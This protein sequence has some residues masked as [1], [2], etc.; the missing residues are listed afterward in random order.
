MARLE[1]SEKF[2]LENIKIKHAINV[3]EEQ[4]I[5]LLLFINIKMIVK[6]FY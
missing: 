1:K 3:K 6:K 5:L 2:I 4:F